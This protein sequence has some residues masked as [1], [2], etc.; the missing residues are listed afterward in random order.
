MPD[1][2][3]NECYWKLKKKKNHT[4]TGDAPL[5]GSRLVSVV[6]SAKLSDDEI[7]N[8]IDILL[9]RQGLTPSA[10]MASESWN[11]VSEWEYVSLFYTI[12]NVEL[13]K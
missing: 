13:T 5:N 4:I 12:F 9:N 1:I 6:K 11:K 10:P 2:F 3:Q 8:L 7:Q